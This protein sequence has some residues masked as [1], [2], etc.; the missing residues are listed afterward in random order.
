MKFRNII[1]FLFFSFLFGQNYAQTS[2]S[3]ISKE[4]TSSSSS[5]VEPLGKRYRGC[6]DMGFSYGIGEGDGFSR[7][8]FSST[9]GYQ[10]VP[11]YLFIGGGVEVDYYFDG[12]G[13]SIPLYFDMRSN[14]GKKKGIPF[15]D[16]RV[17]GSP[18]VIKG[19]YFSPSFGVRI[20]IK[21]TRYGVSL[22]AGYTYQTGKFG[23]YQYRSHSVLEDKNKL[24]CIHFKVGFEW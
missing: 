18:M 5:N 7:F 2:S 13:V 16:V 6:A 14:F 1:V 10:V 22:L 17:G 20:P 19:F 4:K 15:L 8:G 24:N 23:Y 9:H 3:K 21:E 12:K 11:T